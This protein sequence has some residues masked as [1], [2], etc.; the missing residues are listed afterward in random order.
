[1]W[2]TILVLFSYLT[3]FAAADLFHLGRE[4]SDLIVTNC[5]GLEGDLVQPAHSQQGH[6]QLPQLAQGLWSNTASSFPHR[7]TNN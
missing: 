6:L 1:M 4:Q 5:I 7:L 3:Y 2:K